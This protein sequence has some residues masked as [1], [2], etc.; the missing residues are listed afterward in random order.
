MLQN[1][2]NKLSNNNKKMEERRKKNRNK[3]TKREWK[4]IKIFK[5]RRSS[6]SSLERHDD[7]L[8]G[9]DGWF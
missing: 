1:E 2:I 3:T 4:L 9:L 5:P 7:F 6:F 8:N